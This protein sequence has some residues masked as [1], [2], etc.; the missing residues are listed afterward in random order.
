ME[1]AQKLAN[2]IGII[3]KGVLL[4][5]GSLDEIRSEQKMHDASLEDIFLKLVDERA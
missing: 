3:H 2:K 4:S 5:E 1:I